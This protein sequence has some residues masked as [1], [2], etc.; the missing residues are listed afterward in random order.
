MGD[1]RKPRLRWRKNWV[2]RTFLPPRPEIKTETGFQGREKHRGFILEMG[3][4][5]TKCRHCDLEEVQ[6][7]S[8]LWCHHLQNRVIDR[9]PAAEAYLSHQPSGCGCCITDSS[10]AYC[11]T[12]LR[13]AGGK[14]ICRREWFGSLGEVSHQGNTTDRQSEMTRRK[15]K[16]RRRTS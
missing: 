11:V 8:K 14:G 5:G 13:E 2:I 6:G 12:N 9:H 3:Y 4:P 10:Y 16:R 1:Q 7:L 15:A